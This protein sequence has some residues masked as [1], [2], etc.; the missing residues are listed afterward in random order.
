MGATARTAAGQRLVPYGRCTR[1][2]AAAP[3]RR[4]TRWGGGCG[5]LGQRDS[6]PDGASPTAR[7]TSK[8]QRGDT[9]SAGVAEHRGGRATPTAARRRAHRQPGLSRPNGRRRGSAQPGGDQ[10]TLQGTVRTAELGTLARGYGT[11]PTRN[12]VAD[13]SRSPRVHEREPLVLRC[14]RHWPRQPRRPGST[15]FQVQVWTPA[16]R[17]PARLRNVLNIRPQHGSTRSAS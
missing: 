15:T 11:R 12:A 5:G 3:R 2:T 9:R 6:L 16:R 7:P 13:R 4:E 1:H 14:T 17:A 10:Q 8:G